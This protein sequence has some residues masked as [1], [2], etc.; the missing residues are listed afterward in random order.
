MPDTGPKFTDGPPA[1]KAARARG[2]VTPL[3]APD[4]V[5]STEP[6]DDLADLFPGAAP[7][8]AESP[9]KPGEQLL[10]H[11]L[12][13]GFTANG[14][15]WYRGQE[16]EYVV[17]EEE[18]NDTLDIKGQSWLSLSPADQMRRYGR[19]MFG[20]GP[21]PGGEFENLQAL[22]AERERNRKP[23]TIGKLS[24]ASITRS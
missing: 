16:L 9:F 11:I 2:D 24:A 3:D 10:I 5:A 7:A 13:D 8:E 20:I 14:R 4:V 23:P 12:E 21:W 17:G 18:Y 22:K 19:I 1:G 6:D 15:V